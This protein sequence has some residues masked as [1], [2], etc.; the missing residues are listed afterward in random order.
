MVL[1]L[2]G[3]STDLAPQAVP[4][5][6]QAKSMQNPALST[7][8]VEVTQKQEILKNEFWG[9]ASAGVTVLAQGQPR[10]DPQHH[11]GT[12]RRSLLEVAFRELR[13]VGLGLC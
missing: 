8:G 4:Q 5:V 2:S 3:Q 7:P 10:L 13:D 1:G 11:S 12:L 6:P 9:E